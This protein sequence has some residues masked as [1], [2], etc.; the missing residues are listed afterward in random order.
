MLLVATLASPPLRIL[1]L[2]LKLPFS[3]LALYLSEA[4]LWHAPPTGGWCFFRHPGRGIFSGT[5]QSVRTC[6]GGRCGLT[7]WRI[8]VLSL[9]RGWLFISPQ[10]DISL[11]HDKA[12]G[13]DQRPQAIEAPT[14]KGSHLA[15]G[16]A[17]GVD[18]AGTYN[19]SSCPTQPSYAPFKE[20]P[21]AHDG[22]TATKGMVVLHMRAV[23]RSKSQFLPRLCP[24][25]AYGIRQLLTGHADQFLAR[26]TL[27][28]GLLVQSFREPLGIRSV[29][30]SKK[31]L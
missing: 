20:C 10:A 24:A 26:L 22:W 13:G 8:L 14:D 5:P 3:W 11:D 2:A 18:T 25:V 6:M 29:G 1:F 9:V 12:T 27:L 4:Q 19:S 23:E 28:R 31:S 15:T 21:S 30:F 17:I 7:L 16:P